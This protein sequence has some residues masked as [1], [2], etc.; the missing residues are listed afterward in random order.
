MRAK[1]LGCLAGEQHNYDVIIFEF[2]Y[3]GASNCSPAL[4]PADVD[5]SNMEAFG[6]GVGRS[7]ETGDLQWTITTRVTGVN[8]QLQRDMPAIS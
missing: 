5:G 7:R 1:H 3:G 8:V 2:L 6:V 4:V